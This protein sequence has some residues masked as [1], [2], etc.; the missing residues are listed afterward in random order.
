MHKKQNQ[1]DSTHFG[2]PHFIVVRQRD[3]FTHRKVHVGF[4]VDKVVLGRN[5]LQ[6]AIPVIPLILHTQLSSY[7]RST[8][9]PTNHYVISGVTNLTRHLVQLPV[10]KLTVQS[11]IYIEN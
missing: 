5:L 2:V 11:D 1:T 6:M 8:I 10:Q 3:G 9:D 4:L 7:L